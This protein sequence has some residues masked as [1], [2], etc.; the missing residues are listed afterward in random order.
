MQQ[1]SVTFVHLYLCLNEFI[2]DALN[3]E[4]WCIGQSIVD[5]C[6]RSWFLATRCNVFELE[7]C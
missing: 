1:I 5:D 4:I 3:I 2:L 6:G 7:Y